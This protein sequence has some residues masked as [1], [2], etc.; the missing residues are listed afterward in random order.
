MS[1]SILERRREHGV[2]SQ[3]RGLRFADAGHFI[4]PPII[5]T[6]IPWSADLVAGGTAEGN[7]HAQAEAWA[8]R[9]QFL[10][11]HLAPPGR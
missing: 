10:A 7:A 9:L 11:Q 8:A 2:G 1:E 4:R 3:D 6:T 5:P